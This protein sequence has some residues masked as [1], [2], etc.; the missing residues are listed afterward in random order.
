MEKR[1]L[2]Q[3]EPALVCNKEEVA[4]TLTVKAPSEF[5]VGL[6]V[7]HNFVPVTPGDLTKHTTTWVSRSQMSC[8]DFS[9]AFLMEHYLA[10][11]FP[12]GSSYLWHFPRGLVW[13]YGQ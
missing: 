8:I 1:E 10:W 5:G 2:G 13:G 9:S 12:R 11:H 6:C 3:E 4:A 7:Y